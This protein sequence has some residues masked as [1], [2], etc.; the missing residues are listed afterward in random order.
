MALIAKI[1]SGVRAFVIDYS[2]RHN[3]PANACLHLIGVPMTVWGIC[4][5]LGERIIEGLCFFAGGYFLQYLGHKAQGNE[6][7]EVMLLKGICRRLKAL[8]ETRHG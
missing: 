6:V 7:G 2:R 8:G 1:G 3:H 5:L 4:L